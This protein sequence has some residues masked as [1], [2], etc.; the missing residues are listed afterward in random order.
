[1]DDLFY[2]LTGGQVIAFTALVGVF[3]W[4]V[5]IIF[6]RFYAQAQKTRRAE[7]HTAF[8]QGMLNRGMSAEDIQMV[9][10]AGSGRPPMV[11]RL[12]SRL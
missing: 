4:G 8:K 9:C 5:L 11:R 12:R 7:V 6:Q 2:H 1:M 10:D 3:L